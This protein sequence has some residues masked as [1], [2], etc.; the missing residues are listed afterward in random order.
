VTITAW[1]GDT[2]G[3]LSMMWDMATEWQERTGIQIDWI[4]QVGDFGTFPSEDRLDDTSRKH[5]LKHDYAISV[6]V[7]DFPRVLSEEMTVPIPTYFIRGNHEDQEFLLNLERKQGSYCLSHPIEVVPNLFYVPDG[8]IFQLGDHR[9]A[10]WGGCWGA[11]TWD[12]DYWGHARL[13][14]PRRMNHMTRDVFERLRR[15]RFDILVTHDAP[16]GCGL[17]GALNPKG[18]LLDRESLSEDHPDGKGMP[19]IRQLIEETRPRYHFCG[20]WHEFH[21][22]AYGETTSFVLDKT[23]ADGVDRRCME[24]IEL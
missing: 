8:C 13:N 24:I 17:Q 14:S 11:K 16:T 22:T 6:A 5:A 1:F 15:E 3:N 18:L 2:H 21:E 4:F 23:I 20:H 12:M 7:G 19:F 9:I 10:G